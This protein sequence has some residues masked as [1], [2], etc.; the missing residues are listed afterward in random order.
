LSSSV[1]IA[2]EALSDGR[3]VN[4]AGSLTAVVCVSSAAIGTGHVAGAK[5]AKRQ[6]GIAQTGIREGISAVIT[7]F[8]GAVGRTAIIGVGVAVIAPLSGDPHAIPALTVAG[9]SC[10]IDVIASIAGQALCGAIVTAS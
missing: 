9:I 6:A 5:N 4:G 7:A 2:G 1:V 10:I 3:A 8:N